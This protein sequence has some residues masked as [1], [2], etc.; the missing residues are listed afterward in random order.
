MCFHAYRYFF[1]TELESSPPPDG[2]G[3][4]Y[5]EN[6]F[7]GSFSGCGLPIA[8]PPGVLVPFWFTFQES[9]DFDYYLPPT[10][11]YRSGDP[12]VLAAGPAYIKSLAEGSANSDGGVPLLTPR[13]I[14]YMSL[15][16]PEGNLHCD[17]SGTN[18][19]DPC[20]TSAVPEPGTWALLATGLL[21]LG[22]VAWRRKE[23]EA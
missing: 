21:G 2:A 7:H 9:R 8:F 15:W 11:W 16:T 22:F 14:S 17:I 20:Y 19:F 5:I 23:R 12:G 18:G 4:Y 3:V 10:A 13:D 1:L 6:S